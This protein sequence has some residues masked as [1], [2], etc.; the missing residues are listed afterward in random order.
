LKEILNAELFFTV[1]KSFLNRRDW[2][3][4][5]RLA[6]RKAKWDQFGHFIIAD[7]TMD[8]V[9]AD[10]AQHIRFSPTQYKNPLFSVKTGQKHYRAG[11]VHFR[12]AG[13]RKLGDIVVLSDVTAKQAS[14]MQLTKLLIGIS[15]VIS[16][17]LFL[18]FYVYVRSIELRLHKRR[19]SLQ[20]EIQQH[21]QTENK[22]RDAKE[23]AESAR[24][25]IKQ[26]NRQLKFS[27]NRSN[28]LAQQ[29]M[30]ADEAKSQFLANMSHEI[31]TPMNAIIGFSD[32]LSELHLD[33]QQTKYTNII[34]ESS[35]S[36]L[37]LIN[38]ILD[39]SKIEAGEFETECIDCSLKKL[40][41]EVELIMKPAAEKKSL[42]F[43][44]NYSEQLPG[45]I[46]TDPMRLRQC[47]INLVNNAIKFTETGHVHLNTILQEIGG[48]AF[49]RFDVK[50]TGIGIPAKK[51]ETIF[52]A[53]KQADGATTRKYG[54]TGLGLAIARSMITLLGGQLTLESEV[55]KGSVFSLLVP[56]G[57]DV[58]NQPAI[59][60]MPEPNEQ[61]ETTV[62]ELPVEAFS[63]NVLIAEDTRT[64]QILIKLLLEKLGLTVE[65]AED[66]LQA[67]KQALAGSFDLVLMDM[68]M[69]NLSGYG[70][71]RK[72]RGEGFATPI[73]ALT[74]HAMKGDDQKCIDAGCNDYLAKP[75]DRG[76]LLTIIRK[77]LLCHSESPPETA[78]L[79]L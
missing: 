62:D 34:R 5:V 41:A 47:L 78:N 71:T 6:G 25:E 64:N 28:R 10:L 31:R 3:K 49:V 37:Q 44:A 26:V 4:G 32:M 55:G 63:G 48:K 27:F 61:L 14:Q 79:P 24:E 66:G 70:A 38:D 65:I 22:L 42:N 29:A 33:A 8:E 51:C 35:K 54:G 12:D 60:D 18:L 76:K 20:T 58:K 67:V 74:A 13:Q 72:L 45:I 19:E 17:V 39:F 36:L 68:Q 30:V 9:P 7:Q 52:E 57:V 46:R 16:V 69:P 21:K 2:E 73:V 53:F 23:R 40:L 75:I 77:Y 56:A 50:D 15:S 11:Y 1:N 43:E 59:G